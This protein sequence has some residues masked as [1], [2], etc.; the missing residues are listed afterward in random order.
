MKPIFVA[1]RLTTMLMCEVF[2]FEKRLTFSYFTSLV[3]SSLMSQKFFLKFHINLNFCLLRKWMFQMAKDDEKEKTSENGDSDKN[4]EKNSEKRSTKSVIYP[5][6]PSTLYID[7]LKN[8]KKGNHILN[9]CVIYMSFLPAYDITMDDPPEKKE[10]SKPKLGFFEPYKR[11]YAF[12]DNIDMQVLDLFLFHLDQL[13]FSW[14]L[15]DCSVLSCNLLFHHS[16]GSLWATLF[17]FPFYERL[18]TLCLVKCSFLQEGKLG[19]KNISSEYPIDDEFTAS[20]TPAF[21]SMLGLS[22]AMFVAA[23]TQVTCSD[24]YS[25]VYLFVPPENR[26]GNLLDPTSVPHQESLHSQA[27]VDGHF[28]VGIETERTRRCHVARVR[29]KNS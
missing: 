22:I 3:H 1:I 12:A 2:Q 8:S 27:L 25:I 15:L 20:A 11:L 4:S 13:N 24:F 23:F 16:Y 26:M 7:D 19:L 28:V 21:V 5:I 29:V 6:E 10:N 17:L 14:W 9:K 18:E